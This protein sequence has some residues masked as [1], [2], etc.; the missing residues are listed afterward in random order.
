MDK[1]ESNQKKDKNLDNQDYITFDSFDKLNLKFFGEGLLEN[2]DKGVSSS[3]GPKGAY[4]IS[5]NA[6]FGNGK[7]TF[8]EMFKNF[9]Q[10]EKSEKYNV[11]FINAWESDFYKEPV[12]AILS[13]FV[14]WVEE[15]WKNKNQDTK[16]KKIQ[17]EIIDSIKGVIGVLGN[18][19]KQ[20][21]KIT[22]GV[23]LKEIPKAYKTGKNLFTQKKV[24]SKGDDIFNDFKIRIESIKEIKNVLSKYLESNNKKL[25]IIVDE[26]DRTRPDYAIHFLEDMKH[27]F[28]I[29]N[30][31][32]LVAVN[33]KQMEA[34]VKC[35]YGEKL[36][37]EGY[38][39]KFFKQEIDLPDPYEQAQNFVN[40]LIRKTT[41]KYNLETK[42]RSYRVE[43]SYLFCRMFSL[44][45]REI[46]NFIRI[47]E[48]IL[49]DENKIAKWVYQD[50]YSFFICLFLKEREI[51]NQIL[52]GFFTV[53][54][55]I[56]FVKNRK[57]PFKLNEDRIITSDGIITSE[58]MEGI[59]YRNNQILGVTACSFMKDKKSEAD[60]S[61]IVTTFSTL[62]NVDIRKIFSTIEGGFDQVHTYDQN[63]PALDICKKIN[64]CKSFFSRDIS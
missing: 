61:L 13:A 35:L 50:C 52:G 31:I 41:V 42:D 34:T 21:V 46:E 58:R 55:F 10:D 3:V 38:Y 9:I 62:N 27:F 7:T 14:D 16:Q 37:F 2:M 59:E 19:A 53:D 11:L 39:R 22:T 57:F 54:K 23:D 43:S 6:E 5:L 8:L 28:D 47:F 15:E 56:S 1:A 20:G 24:I 29:E 45:L 33:R 44:T 36:D 26:L 12:I 60:K 25:L 30:V 40:E 18:L 48:Q 63:Q 17:K 51:F 49:G 4:T 64:Q 32:F